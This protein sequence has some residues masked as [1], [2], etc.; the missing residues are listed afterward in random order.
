MR[1][2]LA[3]EEN[4]DFDLRSAFSDLAMGAAYGAVAGAGHALL[5]VGWNALK[6]RVQA[7][8]G[9]IPEPLPEEEAP[10]APLPTGPPE[11]PE[12]GASRAAFAAGVDRLTTMPAPEVNAAIG[13]AVGQIVTERPVNV[14]P[15]VQLRTPEPAFGYEFLPT[16]PRP[17]RPGEVPAAAVLP[18]PSAPTGI[19]AIGGAGRAIVENLYGGLYDALRAGKETFAG[20]R[21]PVL[22]AARPAFDRGEINSPEDLQAW[23]SANY[24]RQPS[25]PIAAP[26]VGEVVPN[27]A[28]GFDVHG[29][30]ET[31]AHVETREQADRMSVEFGRLW[32]AR[33]GGA[34]P[35]RDPAAVVDQ[36]R[37][38][39]RV[40]VFPGTPQNELAATAEEARLAGERAAVTRET[41]PQGDILKEEQAKA[42]ED[43]IATAPGAPGVPPP[44]LPER[45]AAGAGAGLGGAGEGAAAG[46]ADDL[47]IVLAEQQA[48]HLRVAEMEPE[49]R[50]ELEATQRALT[51]A[52]DH[53]RALQAAAACQKENEV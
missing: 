21:D 33:Q 49:E 2:G 14:E 44:E 27:P 26:R 51:E 11:G 38:L 17:A 24:R 52:E 13:T 40:G 37:D 36:Q 25:A 4:A 48:Q 16:P 32:M 20:I 12:E 47:R 29:G 30:P 9:A 43:W 42:P 18:A 6:G 50:A 28:G 46:I 23:V 1:Y 31:V 3:R 22:A 15:L 10:R 34:A 41:S 5:G 39:D 8:I 53:T 19:A 45:Q 35:P 7:R